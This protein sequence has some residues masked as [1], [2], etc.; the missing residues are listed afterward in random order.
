MQL[1]IS[2]F[3]LQLQ[4]AKAKAKLQSFHRPFMLVRGQ[5]DANVA[6]YPDDRMLVHEP[7]TSRNVGLSNERV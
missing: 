2:H 7:D 5:W 6:L 3:L 4:E 1:G